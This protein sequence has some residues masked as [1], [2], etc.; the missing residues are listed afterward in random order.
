MALFDPAKVSRQIDAYIASIPPGKTVVLVGNADLKSKSLSL[1]VAVKLH[2]DVLTAYARVTKTFGEDLAAD[3]GFKV[4]F[5]YGDPE[6]GEFSYSELVQLLQC[7]GQGYW[8][9]HFN[10]AKLV[11]GGTVE[12]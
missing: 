2:E 10:A 7:R 1:G 6:D 12:L 5:L 4:S 9:S 8:R 11:L 3:A